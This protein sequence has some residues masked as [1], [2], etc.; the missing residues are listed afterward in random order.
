ML[1]AV[2]NDANKKTYLLTFELG[3]KKND[4]SW[5]WFMRRLQTTIG[6]VNGLVF[7]SYR[8][9]S[10]VKVIVIVFSHIFYALRIYHAS[11]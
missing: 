1:V 9:K 4:V 7:V 11:T 5:T 8:H 6:V 10:I 3:N 2:S